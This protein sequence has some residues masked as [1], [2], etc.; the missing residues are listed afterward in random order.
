MKKWLLT[1]ADRA[2]ERCR[3][4]LLQLL[5]QG[6]PARK[7]R[8][9][10]ATLHTEEIRVYSELSCA[11]QQLYCARH[12]YDHA[13]FRDLLD[14]EAAPTWNK[15][16]VLSRLLRSGKGYDY[17]MWMDA[18]AAFNNHDIALEEV[19]R[20]WPEHDF[21]ISLD[22]P[23][24][25]PREACAGVFIVKNTPWSL[26]FL[27]LW[28]AA[29]KAMDGGKYF[30]RSR[31]G[32]KDQVILNRLLRLPEHAPHF[33]VLPSCYLNE[34]AHRAPAP[35]SFILHAMASSNAQRRVL[36]AALYDRLW[37]EGGPAAQPTAAAAYER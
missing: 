24:V 17:V 16:A 26:G 2:Q 18:D 14:V 25:F 6:G 34:D 30:A 21:L 36:F 32:K 37:R 29:G 13:E 20:L 7:L 23:N 22:P 33:K 15:P 27:D 19:L 10:V 4:G 9:A 3:N 12:G 35:T 28:V 31:K 8:L 5:A 1:Y 11:I